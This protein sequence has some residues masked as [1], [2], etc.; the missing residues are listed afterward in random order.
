MT[1]IFNKRIER[2]ILALSF[3]KLWLSQHGHEKLSL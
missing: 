2:E 1:G 3:I